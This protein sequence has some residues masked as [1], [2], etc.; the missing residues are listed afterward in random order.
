MAT[1][2]QQARL[3]VIF[4]EQASFKTLD[5][6]LSI[7]GEADFLRA[8]SVA[9]DADFSI[10]REHTLEQLSR[11]LGISGLRLRRWVAIGLIKPVDSTA[12]TP[13][14]DYHQVAGAR[15]L[16]RLVARGVSP[17]KL[18]SNLRRLQKWFPDACQLGVSIVAIEKRLLARDGDELIDPHGQLHFEFDSQTH[19]TQRTETST[20]TV[21]A[22]SICPDQLFDLALQNE[23]ERDL[24]EAIAGYT[25]WLNT[26]GDDHQ[27]LFNLAN[28]YAQKGL[29][30]EAI[31]CYQRSVEIMPNYASAWN[32]LGLC[33]H[34]AGARC[35]AI[36]AL[37]QAVDLAP[38][39]IDALFNLADMLDEAGSVP[40]ARLLWLRI[41]KHA[42]QNDEEL[43]QYAR[44]RLSASDLASVS[45]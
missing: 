32:N 25:H 20:S 14:F 45:Q 40:E 11:L 44:E 18:A 23:L 33:L 31:E 37:R 29:I 1:F 43:N 28:V 6:G 38:V 27:V 21:P 3:L 26:F 39:N 24:D 8:G 15:T 19:V 16:S 22:R 5:I 35:D 4:V 34:Q 9:G 41:V 36:V 17:S 12:I 42:D 13:T 2:A 10:R 7:V 30:E